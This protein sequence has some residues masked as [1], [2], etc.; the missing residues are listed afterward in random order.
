[1]AHGSDFHPQP[2]PAGGGGEYP[3]ANP[4]AHPG[5]MSAA[6]LG[7]AGARAVAE[8]AAPARA[9]LSPARR[10]LARLARMVEQGQLT[11][12]TPAG[13]VIRHAGTQPGPQAELILHRWRAVRRLF[14][15]GDIG[16]AE[17]FMDGDWS[18]PDLT[19]VIELAARNHHRM[20]AALN[21]ARLARLANR[22]R[23]AA[24]RNTRAGSRRNIPA[25]YDLG[26]EFYAAW[27]DRG[28]SYSS[29]FYSDPAQDLESAQ[30]AKQRLV[31]DALGLRGGERVLEIGCGWGGL[32]GR[33]AREHGC[34]VVG[35]TLSPAQLG[36]ARESLADATAP[37]SVELRLQDYRDTRGT[38]D[39]VVSVEMLEAVGKEYWPAYF[40][41]VRANL[42]PGG[43]AAVQV[44][45]MAEDRYDAYARGTDFIQRHIF[46]GGMLPSEAVMRAEIAAAGMVLDDV[47]RFGASYALTLAEWRRRF[48]QAWPR[49]VPLG[50][51]AAFRR[52]W[53][54][55]LA[56][57]E[58]G[59]RAGAIDVGLYR[60]HRPA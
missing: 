45:T 27:L 4:A 43:V 7:A 42:R 17:S 9:W 49:L 21:G 24:R 3:G 39:R 2:S 44:I 19:A 48:E 46:P 20:Q 52:K 36:F 13:T 33:L 41:A 14:F 8:A 37:G 28:M 11:I 34:H 16:F 40:G 54:Y 25:H 5:G 38:F 31:M 18:T 47:R 23:H 56:Y 51:D 60:L 10:F 50:F 29:A 59:F 55:Y 1:M 53:N 32:A 57:C 15:G 6:M 58:A 35:L 12:R 26:N 22:L 30:A